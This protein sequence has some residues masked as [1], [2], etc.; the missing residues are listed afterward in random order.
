MVDGS[1]PD[2]S[3]M[4]YLYMSVL[5]MGFS[6]AMFFAQAMLDHLLLKTPGVEPSSLL[7]AWVPPPSVATG[8]AVLG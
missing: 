5:P 4:I 8:A 3:E 2:A 7:R 6:W 1:K